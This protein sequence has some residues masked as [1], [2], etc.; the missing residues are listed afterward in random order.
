MS[1]V[2][3]DASAV[4][5]VLFREP[6]AEFVTERAY[7]GILSS[8]CY[9]EI[10]VKLLDR[11]LPLEDAER[12]M[13]RLTLDIVPFDTELAELAASF[14]S[15]T[16]ALGLSFADR[17]CLALGLKSG[18]AVLT[19]DRRWTEASVGVIVQLIR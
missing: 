12:L 7:G 2:V 3:L 4:L 5:A 13:R 14:R 11:S 6:G 17:A 15:H 8:V 1:K 10:L 19:A 9:S 18:L 16:R